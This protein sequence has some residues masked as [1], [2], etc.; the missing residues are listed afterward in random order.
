LPR[1]RPIVVY[2][3]GG[4]RSVIAASILERQGFAQVGDLAGGFSAWHQTVAV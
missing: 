3:E 1:D 4:F 2:C